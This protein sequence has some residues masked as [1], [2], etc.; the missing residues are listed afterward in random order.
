MKQYINQLPNE[1]KGY[2]YVSIFLAAVVFFFLSTDWVFRS[3]PLVDPQNAVFWG[4]LGG[5]L[6]GILTIATPRKIEK[7]K[8]EVRQ[9]Y[10]L[11]LGVSLLTTIGASLLWIGLDLS[12]SGISAL[13]GKTEFLFAIV[14]G[15][16]FLKERYT[17]LQYLSIPIV[18]LGLYFITQIKTEVSFFVVGLI[19]LSRLCYALQSM[20][21]KKYGGSMDSQSFA[22]LRAF[23]MSIIAFLTVLFLGTFEPIPLVAFMVLGINQFFGLYLGRIFFFEAHKYL[24]ISKINFMMIMEPILVLIGSVLLF[25]DTISTQKMMGATCIL[26]G[27]Y[28]FIKGR[29]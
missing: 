7:L 24:P 3:Y 14:L 19:L 27:L 12:N 1:I 9:N 4:F 22:F 10:K 25:G 11:I 29:K 15:A 26:I 13:I 28:L 20:L 17:P 5:V 16:L 23:S 2:L 8:T 21:V 6:L 18:F